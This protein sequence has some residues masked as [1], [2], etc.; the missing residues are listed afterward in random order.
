LWG[1]CG[2]G[3]GMW[4]AFT[5]TWWPIYYFSLSWRHSVCSDTYS[6]PQ[7]EHVCRYPY[8]PGRLS[9]HCL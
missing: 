2:T 8:R 3:A 6:G 1:K 4:V 7:L 9:Q 5:D